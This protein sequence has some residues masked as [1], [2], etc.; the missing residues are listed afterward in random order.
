MYRTDARIAISKARVS[1]GNSRKG[2]NLIPQTLLK[3]D[4]ESVARPGNW[5]L[6]RSYV[7]L[8]LFDNCYRLDLTI[9]F[10]KQI[11]D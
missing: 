9:Q 2:E 8:T 10:N 3:C 4:R 11:Q 6:A 7:Y 1:S 5:E